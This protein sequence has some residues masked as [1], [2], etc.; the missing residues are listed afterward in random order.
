MTSTEPGTPDDY[1]IPD[2]YHSTI[3]ESGK[4]LFIAAT[5]L[6]GERSR[7]AQVAA[8]EAIAQTVGRTYHHFDPRGDRVLPKGV[9]RQGDTGFA[10][11]DR[12]MILYQALKQEWGLW[13]YSQHKEGPDSIDERLARSV[14]GVV[15]ACVSYCPN[16][17]LGMNSAMA[18][19]SHC[20]HSP[21][22]WL[23]R[24]AL[25]D[26]YMD[27]LDDVSKWPFQIS[28]ENVGLLQKE[29]EANDARNRRAGDLRDGRGDRTQWSFDEGLWDFGRPR[30]GFPGEQA[31][32]PDSE[33]SA[34]P[35]WIPAA[36]GA[37]SFRQG[38]MLHAILGPALTDDLIQAVSAS[39]MQEGTLVELT[40]DLQQLRVRKYSEMLLLMASA[41]HATGIA[42][43]AVDENDFPLLRAGHADAGKQFGWEVVEALRRFGVD[44][45]GDRESYNRWLQYAVEDESVN[46]HWHLRH[47]DIEE[48]E[49][50]TEVSAEMEHRP[51]RKPQLMDYVN[52]AAARSARSLADRMR[53]KR[54]GSPP[55]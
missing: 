25:F 39:G 33:T 14:V 3:L 55:V 40:A 16:E 46:L 36:H 49:S 43:G 23:I 9:G 32:Q 48:E 37:P 6:D 19:L 50:G 12:H 44:P 31:D 35:P 7:E 52:R 22:P 34:T 10:V 4:D 54:R 51:R 15:L 38:E 47:P 45:S 21:F 24:D 42:G 26:A 53:S 1:Q 5:H 13:L 28:G 2:G 8:L 18:A 30:T 20:V 41:A 27:A 29:I 11:Y 17:D